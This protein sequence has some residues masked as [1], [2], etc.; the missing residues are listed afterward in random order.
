[1]LCFD[2]FGNS[3]KTVESACALGNLGIS[4]AESSVF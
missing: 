2:E 3:E 4:V 1:M